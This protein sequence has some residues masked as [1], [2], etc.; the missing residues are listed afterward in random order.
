[1]QDIVTVE[2]T[3]GDFA[4]NKRNLL[5]AVSGLVAAA[6]LAA[7]AGSAVQESTGEYVD[8]SVITTKVKSQLITSGDTSGTSI[9]V[10]TFKGTVQ[11][12]G[13]VDT[14]EEKQRAESIAANVKGVRRVEN[15]LTV[16]G[17]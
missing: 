4:M 8:D 9:S 5:S 13:F 16:K 10:E 15:R 2:A 7:C 6:M 14:E 1:L 12:S 3:K 11:L 17:S